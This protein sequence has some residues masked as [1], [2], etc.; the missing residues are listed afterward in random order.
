MRYNSQNINIQSL[1]SWFNGDYTTVDVLRLD[2]IH[3]VISGNKWFKLKYYL[4]AAER[5]GKNTIASF[6]GAYSNHIAALA[7]AGREHG[8]KTIGFIRGEAHS[9]LSHTLTAAQACGMELVFINRSDYRFKDAIIQTHA[10]PGWYWI[11]EGGYG[12]EGARGASEILKLV[13]VSGYSHI[14]CAVGTGT[15]MAGLVRTASANQE[16]IGISVMKGNEALQKA[17]DDL[18]DAGDQQKQ[19]RILHDYHFGGYGKHPSNLVR[20]MQGLWENEQLPTDIVYTSKLLFAVKDCIEKKYFHKNSRL[21][22]I[23]SGG[24]QGNNSL[25]PHTLPF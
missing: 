6:G 15:M 20:F 8:L 19:H 5:T 17:V 24:L 18:L 21:L 23:H 10:D 3:P 12:P 2:R 9:P 16:V 1:S 4:E 14:L 22:V 25:P 7:Y 11:P 13:D